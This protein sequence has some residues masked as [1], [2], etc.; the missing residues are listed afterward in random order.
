MRG[1]LADRGHRRRVLKDTRVVHIR[2][3]PFLVIE[4]SN[5]V[6]CRRFMTSEWIAWKLGRASTHELKVG[7][8]V[9]E[10]LLERV[11]APRRLHLALV[12]KLGP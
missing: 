12:T 6:S 7:E 3:R 11:L 5:S 10:V 8:V 9:Q 4:P 1:W 2:M